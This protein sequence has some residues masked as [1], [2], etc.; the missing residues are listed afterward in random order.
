MSKTL[1]LVSAGPGVSLTLAR[2]FGA[3]GLRTGLIAPHRENLD[4]CV[5]AL[6]ATPTVAPRW[7]PCSPPS[8]S[9]DPCAG[10]SYRGF[11]VSS[12]TAGG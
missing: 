12:E 6:T 1:A 2:R 9:G 4:R 10:P 3:E 5:A 7:L 11:I 8:C